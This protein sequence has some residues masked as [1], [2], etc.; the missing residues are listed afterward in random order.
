[1]RNRHSVAL[2]IETSNSYARGVLEGVVDYVRQHEGWS[3]ICP[4]RNAVGGHR[5]GCRDGRATESS[6]ELNQTRLP[7]R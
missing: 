1:M 2:L 6:R 3:I 4:S 7:V 5:H